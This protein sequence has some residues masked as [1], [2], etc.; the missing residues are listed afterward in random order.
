MS[1]EAPHLDPVCGMTVKP[2][3]P[4]RHLHAGLEYRFCSEG[5]LVKFRADPDRYLAG[6]PELAPPNA[7]YTC[8]MH[9][10]VV[11]SG[12]GPCPICGMA[13]EVQGV[14][15]EEAP[16]PE[17]ETMTRRFWIGLGPLEETRDW[18]GWV[19]W[20]VGV[21]TGFAALAALFLWRGAAGSGWLVRGPML[22]FPLVYVLTHVLPHYRFPID[23]LVV[24][25]GLAV[26]LD[27]WKRLTLWRAG[28]PS[29]RTPRESP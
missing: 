4:H 16:D 3:G 14:S 1:S 19:E 15:L 6:S 11:R 29:P 26:F 8:P 22:L 21:V 23:G 28:G 20:V 9:P 24:L 25:A 13:L 12:P 10:E 5:C 2:D 17:L 27:G 7:L 18:M